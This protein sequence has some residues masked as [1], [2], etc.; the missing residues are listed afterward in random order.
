MLDPTLTDLATRLVPA[1]LLSGVHLGLERLGRSRDR[2]W[3]K[4]HRIGPPYGP[5][6][7]VLQGA[8]EPLEGFG[9]RVALGWSRDLKTGKSPPYPV[10]TEAFVLRLQSGGRVIIPAG[11]TLTLWGKLVYETEPIAERSHPAFGAKITYA[12]T[13]QSSAPLRCLVASS[14]PLWITVQLSNAWNPADS[15]VFRESP[16]IES[17]PHEGGASAWVTEPDRYLSGCGPVVAGFVA[18]FA[19]PAALADLHKVYIPAMAI[20]LFWLVIQLLTM[21]RSPRVAVRATP[22]DVR[23]ADVI[24]ACKALP[25]EA[26][27]DAQS[28]EADTSNEHSR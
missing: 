3:E 27:Q 20:G 2:A 21:P 25:D 13:D 22:T 19:V 4:I 26:D 9:S 11:Q 24:E 5:G 17:L 7:V 14:T 23:V 10:T 6:A 1:I 18:L 28:P 12:D 15:S 16:P 8:V